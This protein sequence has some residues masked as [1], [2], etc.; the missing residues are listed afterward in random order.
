MDHYAT[1]YF[2]EVFGKKSCMQ[3]ANP[4]PRLIERNHDIDELI[5]IL[6][7]QDQRYLSDGFIVTENGRYIGLGT[8]DQLVRSVTELRLEAAR[9]NR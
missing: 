8:G 5:G 4:A 2:R 7:S 1:L 3:Y 6:T 9:R